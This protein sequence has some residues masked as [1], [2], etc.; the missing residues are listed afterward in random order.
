VQQVR[1]SRHPVG[2]RDPRRSYRWDPAIFVLLWGSTMV[3]R[4]LFGVKSLSRC[5]CCATR[6]VSAD[7]VLQALVWRGCVGLYVLCV[8]ACMLMVRLISVLQHI[9]R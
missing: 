8:G 2:G 9:P 4:L 1:E 6:T 5:K 7:D 3:A